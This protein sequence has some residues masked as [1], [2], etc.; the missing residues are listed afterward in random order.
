MVIFHSYYVS[1]PEGINQLSQPT[2]GGQHSTR[3]IPQPRCPRD[4]GRAAAGAHVLRVTSVGEGVAFFVNHLEG[5]QLDT[6]REHQL[7]PLVMTNIA[8]V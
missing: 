6:V 4:T 2:N 8:M 7:Y 5:M 3:E 1:S